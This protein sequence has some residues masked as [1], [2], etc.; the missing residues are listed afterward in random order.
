[1][2]QFLVAYMARGQLAQSRI[3]ATARGL[4]VQCLFTVTV[5]GSSA[6]CL[7]FNIERGLLAQFLNVVIV[8]LVRDLLAQCLFSVFAGGLFAQ[9]LFVVIPR[10]LLTQCPFAAR[11]FPPIVA[12]TCPCAAFAALVSCW[13]VVPNVYIT[14][15]ASD[16]VHLSPRR[17]RKPLAGSC[18]AG[19]TV[20]C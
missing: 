14:H 3:A 2:A 7:F 1:M 15:P 5:R 11:D 6:Q 4:L 19:Q 13:P 10:W 16:R 18:I 17:I 9:C 12:G 20:G 8:I